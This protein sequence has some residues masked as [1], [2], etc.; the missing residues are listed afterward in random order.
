MPR[1][2]HLGTGNFHRAHQAWYTHLAGGWSITGSSFRS[3]TMRDTLA[4]QNFDYMLVINGIDAVPHKI[5]VIDDILFAP[6]QSAALHAAMVDDDTAIITLTISE[7]GYGLDG[8]VAA[9][10]RALMA[11]TTPV[12]VISCD[13]LTGNGDH[14]AGLVKT[15]AG[16]D[17]P[18]AVT[19]PNSM[20]DRITPATTPALISDVLDAT[21]F[22]DL[23]PVATEPFSEWVIEDTFAGPRPD[24]Q[25]VGVQFVD[26][27]APFELRKLR[28]LNGAHSYLA[29]AGINA[30]Y[31]FVHQAIMDRALRAG[32]IGVM[33]EAAATLPDGLDPATYRDALIKRF[34]NPNLHHKLRQIAM[35]GTQKLPIRLGG[36]L[37]DLGHAPHCQAGIDAWAQFAQSETR[38]GRKLDDPKAGEIA[39]ADSPE[40]LKALL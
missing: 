25:K 33:E 4:A 16:G 3:A 36:T 26:D 9:L 2:V 28:M 11:R 23:A 12:T 40:A 24:W 1:I 35:D 6:D 32:A 39:K 34:E 10:T 38:A 37:Q 19:F 31:E 29:Y 14:L 30:G 17:L 5:P 22:A 21:G 20:V 18:V 8:P 15:C 13:N 7:K 27:V